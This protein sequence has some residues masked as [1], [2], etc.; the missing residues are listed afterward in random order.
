[1]YKSEEKFTINIFYIF[2]VN[3]DISKNIPKNKY[4]LKFATDLLEHL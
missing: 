4:S 2:T 3:F 1:M